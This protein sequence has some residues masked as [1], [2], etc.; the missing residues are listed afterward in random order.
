M[1]P[2]PRPCAQ[3]DTG[4][5]TLWIIAALIAVL[6]IGVSVFVCS[7]SKSKKFLYNQEKTP[8]LVTDS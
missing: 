5:V 7:T 2:P 3:A 6:S 1:P 8:A 4:E